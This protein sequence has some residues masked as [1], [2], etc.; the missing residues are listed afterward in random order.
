MFEIILENILLF[1][2]DTITGGEIECSF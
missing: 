2:A 1:K